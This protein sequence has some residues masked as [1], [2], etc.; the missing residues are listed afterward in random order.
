MRKGADSARPGA[1]HTVGFLRRFLE[2]ASTIQAVN[3]ERG[4]WR[5]FRRYERLGR[6][7]EAGPEAGPGRTRELGTAFGASGHVGAPGL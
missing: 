1:G 4:A 3:R 5:C 6:R 2:V 7:S